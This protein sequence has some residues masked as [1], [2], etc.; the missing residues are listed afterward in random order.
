[1]KIAIISVFGH[2]ECLGSFLELLKHDE[3]TV[4]LTPTTDKYKWLDF[5]KKTYT[6]NIDFN[7][8]IHV[9]DYSHVIKLTSNDDCL[10]TDDSTISLLHLKELQYVNNRSKCYI[11][12]TPY[13]TG[14]NVHYM[15]PIFKPITNKSNKQIITFIGYYLNNNI[16]NDTDLFIQNNQEYQF[17]F[18]VWGDTTYS[19]LNRYSNVKVLQHI[20][21]N[22]LVPLIRDSKYMLSKKYINFDRFSGQ[23]GMAM[24]F[25]KPLII[26]SKTAEA[27]SL[28]GIIFKKNYSEVKLS[29]VS[30]IQYDGLLEDI[31]TFN[32]T[33][34][35]RNTNTLKQIFT[36]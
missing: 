4:I 2:M 33:C 21:T 30:D 32:D 36:K 22:V 35:E 12:L 11:T 25:R 29:T 6:F 24:S 34:I 27:Y 3:V 7:L 8:N 10:H 16:D 14:E 18:V 15:F 23:L 1:M 17:I 26:D 5:Y 9:N 20:Q 28:P 13:I 31:K 19:R